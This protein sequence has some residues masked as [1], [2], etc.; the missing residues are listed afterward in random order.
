MIKDSPHPAQRGFNVPV[1]G[2]QKPKPKAKQKTTK[3]TP[4][5][6][7]KQKSLSTSYIYLKFYKLLC[8]MVK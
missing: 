3:K 6:E 5:I 4:T 8:S 2:N 1:G 7:K